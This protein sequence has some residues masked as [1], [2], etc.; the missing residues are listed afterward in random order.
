MRLGGILYVVSI[1]EGIEDKSAI[2]LL[3]EHPIFELGVQQQ[4]TSV[5]AEDD[6]IIL[7]LVDFVADLVEEFW[8]FCEVWGCL[9]KFIFQ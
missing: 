6:V 7:V 3:E 1:L 4:D 9:V 8:K 2:F 5:H